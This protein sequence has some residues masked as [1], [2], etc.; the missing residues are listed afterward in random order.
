[1][2][3]AV[4]IIVGVIFTL[5]IVGVK[6]RAKEKKLLINEEFIKSGKSSFDIIKPLRYGVSIYDGEEQYYK[7]LELFSKEQSYIS[8]LHWYFSEV[9]NGGH[10]QFYGNSTGIV[11]EEALAG[12]KAVGL[13]DLYSIIERSTA[14]MDGSPSKDRSERE[15]RL[16]AMCDEEEKLGTEDTLGLLDDEIYA[17]NEDVIEQKYMEYINTNKEKFYFNGIMKY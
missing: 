17:L 3:I 4:L 12:A 16:Q 2:K 13:D 15:D 9:Y 1:M 10:N 6:S 7:Y 5:I 11:W 8:A 14:F